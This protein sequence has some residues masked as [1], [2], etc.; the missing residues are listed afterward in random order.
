[1]GFKTPADAIG[2]TVSTGMN[3]KKGSIVGVLKDFN[4]TSLHETIAPFFFTSDRQGEHAVS[5]KISGHRAINNFTTAVEKINAAWA[6]VYPDEKSDYSF[7]DQMIASLYATEQKTSE[8]M[9]AAMAVAILI[10]CMGLFGLAAFTARQ[11][12]KEIGIRKVLGATAG[13]IALLLTKDF[14]RLVVIAI[15]VASP[16]AYYFMY[17]WLQGFAYRINISVWM[18]LFAGFAAMAVAVITVSFQS[19]KAALTS[20]VKSLKTE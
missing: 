9:N 20:P 6:A 1:M 13:N 14:L 11:R 16:L 17:H 2:K 10:S 8:L 3:N 19:I 5:V 18:F 7:F 12:V 4:A 15:V